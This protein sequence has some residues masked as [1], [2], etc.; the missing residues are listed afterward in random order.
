MDSS[1][2]LTEFVRCVRDS[3]AEMENK[4][5]VLTEAHQ[6]EQKLHGEAAA[7]LERVERELRMEREKRRRVVTD[8][9]ASINVNVKDF[10]P[11]VEEASIAAAKL[12]KH[13]P[14]PLEVNSNG[15]IV[16]TSAPS[17]SSSNGPPAKRSRGRPPKSPSPMSSGVTTPTAATRSGTVTALSSSSSSSSDV[18]EL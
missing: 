6:L 16:T 12:S 2:A 3:M 9:L 1:R 4:M 15:Y 11:S 5:K 14:P 13:I 10:F 17:S 18:F 7:K 8:V